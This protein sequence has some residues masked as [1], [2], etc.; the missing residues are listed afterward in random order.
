[1]SFLFP[2]SINF[3]WDM[4]EK[5]LA[6]VVV[7]MEITGVSKKEKKMGESPHPSL[8]IF[9]PPQTPAVGERGKI[10]GSGEKPQIKP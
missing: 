3:T 8:I 1:M 9:L 6:K 2:L 4:G 10:C 7:I 5:I